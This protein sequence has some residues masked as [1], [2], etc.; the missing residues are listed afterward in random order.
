MDVQKDI[1]YLG[2]DFNKFRQNLID[3]TKQYFPTTYN[4][5]NESDPG[6]MMLELASYVG[7]VLSYYTDSNLK[8][9]LLDHASELG[10]VH[11][12]ARMLGF[13][14][15]SV[16][17]AHVTLDVYQLVP[18]IGV[19]DNV[20]PDFNYAL[21]IKPGMR[22]RST[23]GTAQF[24]TTDYVDFT[25]SSS[26]QPTEVTIYESDSTTNLPTYYLLKKQVKAVSG[27]VKTA[28]FTFTQPVPYDKVVLPDLNVM[29]IVSV[30]ESDGDNWYHVPYLAQDTIIDDVPNLVENDPELSQY[31][32][33]V[34]NLLKL[35]RT[36]K[37]FITRLRAD[38]K[39][40]LQFGAGISS[41]N[42]EE[43]IP[44]PD[45]V[46]N[47]LSGFRRSID[48]DIDP[49]NFLYTR[50]YGQAPANTTL[51]VTYTVGTGISDNVA[52]NTLK[53]IDFISFME[54]INNTA[55]GAVVL[56]AKRSVA[57]DNMT[58]AVGAKFNNSLQEI[59][60]SAL[61]NFATQNRLVTAH[62][63]I[64][65]CYSMPGRFGSVSK[66][67]IVPDDQIAQ[68]QQV[69]TTVQNPL[70]M[71][72]Y[73][74]GYNQ[75]KQLTQL[76]QAVKENLKNYLDYY[77]IVTD[78]VNI[79]DAF[80]INISLDY[81]ITVLPNYNSNAVLLQVTNNL[82]EYFNIDRWSINQPIIRS[83]II[84]IIGN[85]P[86][87]Q[88]VVKVLMNNQ[89]DSE[90]GYSGN[91]YDLQGATR[92][93][94]VYPSLDPSIFEVKFPDSDIRGRVVNY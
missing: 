94:I 43:I 19:G 63:Y 6:M 14:V 12:L 84:N 88:N 44:N 65:R 55:L 37:R 48:I 2:K 35:K 56:F 9:S 69:Q 42:D 86:G 71:N 16:S 91:M 22:V 41:N 39:T 92:N 13:N 24:R 78:A 23:D 20:A 87:V 54:N 38:G 1:S 59:K 89:F 10:N 18:A 72:L 80:I 31:R 30:E 46:G 50:T 73:V 64:I 83:E 28:T 81:E 93:G 66:A 34:T 85:V 7:D 53:Q 15:K 26:L 33:S 40:E 57:V 5:F 4:D 79:K 75:S 62:D 51:T 49:S 58:P 67:Y 61:G 17:P 29:E 3:F 27:E 77:R 47:G 21:T 82:K 52:S 32:S 68:Q 25:A 70:A 76:N 45:N 90:L 36:S 8:E 60:N 74:L 11:D